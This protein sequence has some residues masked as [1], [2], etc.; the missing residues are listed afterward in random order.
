MTIFDYDI[1]TYFLDRQ[2]VE[3][4]CD[5]ERRAVF[6]GNTF[7][8]FALTTSLETT[9]DS[10]TD[11][12]TSKVA[13]VESA[14]GRLRRHQ[15]GIGKKDLQAAKKYGRQERGHPRNNGNKT[16][17]YTYNNIVYISNDVTN[18]EITSY[19]IPITL[20]RVMIS[21]E[22]EQAHNIAKQKIQQDLNVWT[23]NTVLV[24][25]TSGSMRNSDI[26]DTRTR[27]DAVW[28]AIS[29]DFVAQRI[30]SGLAGLYDV[31]SIISLGS[32]SEYIIKEMPTSW[33]LYNTVVGFYMNK[34]IVPRSHGNYLP[35]LD[36]AEKLLR[37]NTNKDMAL[38]L[39]FF[40]DGKPSDHIYTE[41]IKCR[42]ESL[43]SEFGRR[44]TFSTIGIGNLD[45]FATLELMVEAAKDY[46]AIGMFQ[47]PSLSSSGIGGA[48]SSVA[49]SLT[50]TQL[51][52]KSF[53]DEKK[54]RNV[55][56]ESRKVASEKVTHV[57][58]KDYYLYAKSDVKRTM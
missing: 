43:A 15:R 49:S 44:L 5:D 32:T 26:W 36:T 48:F 14:H 31:V 47:L 2:R 27:L 28:I 39:S 8:F 10:N 7:S 19:A 21:R 45:D 52:L 57:S 12:P 34:M 23:S 58:E 6:F 42:V 51:E 33:I 16:T 46:G 30:E 24:V 9:M 50:E 35:C 56:Q 18:E 40:S 22:M 1:W 11:I 17:K 20:D 13:F 25:D 53:G 41:E 29:L 38:A 55:R 37:R 54:L 3:K 4:H